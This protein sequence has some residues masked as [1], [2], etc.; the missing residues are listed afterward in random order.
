MNNLS[1][2]RR[3]EPLTLHSALPPLSD[4][5]SQSPTELFVGAEG[6]VGNGGQE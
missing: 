6:D 5:S 4:C 1:N 3:G 2:I